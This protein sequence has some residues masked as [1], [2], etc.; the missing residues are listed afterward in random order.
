MNGRARGPFRETMTALVMAVPVAF[1]FRATVAEARFIPSE[2]MVPTLEVGDRLLVEKVTGRFAVPRRGD[3]LVFYRPHQPS[4]TAN[5]W[6]WLGLTA[7]VPLIKRVIG[8]PGETIQVAKGQVRINGQIIPEPYIE[9][10]PSYTLDP[11]TIP[12]DHLFMLG[13]NRNNSM[14]SHIWGP[15]PMSNVIGHAVARFWPITRV[16]PTD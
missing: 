5:V 1:L 9:H 11:V 7:D 15:L 13:D 14:D 2:S 16:G 8:L 12:H 3:I 10:P 4:A 6:R